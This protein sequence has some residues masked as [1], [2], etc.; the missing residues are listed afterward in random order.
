[1]FAR[2]VAVA[3]LAVAVPCGGAEIVQLAVSGRYDTFTANELWLALDRASLDFVAAKIAAHV[4]PW[5]WD[6]VVLATLDLPAW[7]MLG[8][9]ALFLMWY[10]PPRPYPRF[11]KKRRFFFRPFDSGGGRGTR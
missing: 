7:A 11:L 6:P 5:V 8:A 3:L 9:P 4:A 10:A 1:M 2:S